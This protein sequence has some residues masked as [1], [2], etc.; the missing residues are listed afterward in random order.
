VYFRL[1]AIRLSFETMKLF[2]L[3]PLLWSSSVLATTPPLTSHATPESNVHRRDLVDDLIEEFVDAIKDAVECSACNVSFP[4]SLP[5]F[6]RAI[7]IALQTRNT[8]ST[9]SAYENWCTVLRRALIVSSALVKSTL[10]QDDGLFVDVFAGVCKLLKVRVLLSSA[11]IL[12]FNRRVGP[13]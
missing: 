11:E 7:E 4:F 2:G 10:A 5:L 13:R 1:G 9:F 3:L 8:I 12:S 6:H